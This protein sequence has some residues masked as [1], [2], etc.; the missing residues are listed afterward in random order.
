MHTVSNN[1]NLQSWLTKR[2]KIFMHREN[3][4]HILLFLSSKLLIWVMSLCEVLNNRKNMNESWYDSYFLYHH[5]IIGIQQRPHIKFKIKVK[6]AS[7]FFFILSFI[8]LTFDYRALVFRCRLSVFF[9]IDIK[10]SPCILF[11]IYYFCVI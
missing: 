7:Y 8:P 1:L 2:T 11:I 5:N 10:K 6:T 3:L 9:F 4:K